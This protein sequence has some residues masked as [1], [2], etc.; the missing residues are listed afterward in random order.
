[1][2]G[3]MKC[4]SSTDVESQNKKRKEKN[5]LMFYFRILRELGN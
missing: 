4:W 1:M 2:M 5:L 3:C